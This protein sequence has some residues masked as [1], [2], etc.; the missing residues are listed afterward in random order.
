MR[1]DTLLIVT[2][3]HEC[4]G[5][6]AEMPRFTECGAKVEQLGDAAGPI[7]KGEKH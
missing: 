4:G 3:D 7:G 2:G 5:L 1:P 6:E